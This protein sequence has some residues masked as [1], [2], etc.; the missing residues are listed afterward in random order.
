MQNINV[1]C[2]YGE[3]QI[4]RRGNTNKFD[5]HSKIVGLQRNYFTLFLDEH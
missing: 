4:Q 5:L 2:G 3:V 1:Y